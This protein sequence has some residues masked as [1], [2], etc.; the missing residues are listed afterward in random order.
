MVKISK[1]K[2]KVRKSICR[3]PEEEHAEAEAPE[4]DLAA[5]EASEEAR[6]ADLAVAEA[7]EEAHA[8]ALEVR[9]TEALEA[10]GITARGISGRADIT[11]TEVAA[12]LAD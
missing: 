3:D 12:V 10:R 2:R 9:I 4:V 6:A 5:A 1:N 7:S 8:V 11:I